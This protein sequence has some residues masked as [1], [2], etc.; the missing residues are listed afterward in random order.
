[1]NPTTMATRLKSFCVLINEGG[2]D[3]QRKV[4]VKQFLC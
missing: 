2:L 3:R 1:M 4:D